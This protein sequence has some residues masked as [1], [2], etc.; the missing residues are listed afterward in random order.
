M[1]NIEKEYANHG[2]GYFI[3]FFALISGILSLVLISPAWRLFLYKPYCASIEHIAYVQNFAHKFGLISLIAGI[4][5][6]S[7]GYYLRKTD[8]KLFSRR[9]FVNII[10]ISLGLLIPLII[11][12]NL[13]EVVFPRGDHIFHY[14]EENIWDLKPG[15]AGKY[16]A[17]WVTIN[18]QGFRGE[19]VAEGSSEKEQLFFVGNSVTFGY[20]LELDDSIPALLEKMLNNSRDSDSVRCV[21][22]GVPG[23]KADQEFR[24]LKRYSNLTI[25]RLF[26]GFCYNDILHPYDF[27]ENMP[28]AS[29]FIDILP[30]GK[31]SIANPR[32]IALNNLNIYYTCREIAKK[33]RPPQ[34][35]YSNSAELYLKS[36]EA[37]SDTNHAF[38]KAAWRVTLSEMDSIRIFAES[39]DIPLTLLIFPNELIV[40]KETRPGNNNPAGRL[41]EWAERNTIDYIDLIEIFQNELKALNEDSYYL[42]IEGNHPNPIGNRLIARHIAVYLDSAEID[43]PITTTK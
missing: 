33:I 8:V 19:P 21:N 28:E 18:N 16:L 9:L 17:N 14:D 30:L 35:R 13:L 43:T 39:R 11:I 1:N 37:I 32:A 20:N 4:V 36:V 12:E 38:G 6:F 41:I 34:A 2:L 42:F 26:L 31:V 29:E 23:Y 10:V 27:A 5:L 40:D 15:A 24:K 7:V 25:D 22:L 3:I